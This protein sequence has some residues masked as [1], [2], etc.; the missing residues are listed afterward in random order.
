MASIPLYYLG[1]VPHVLNPISLE[2]E[3]FG[4]LWLE[5][6]NRFPI[7]VGYW[8]MKE[9][10]EI[11]QNAIQ[12]GFSKWTEVSEHYIVMNMYRSIR[13]KQQEQDWKQRTRLSIRMIFK[14]PWR[15]VP[16]GLYVIK[17]RETFPLHASAICKKKFFVWLEHAAVCETEQELQAFIRRVQKEHHAENIMKAGS[18][19]LK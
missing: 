10:S 11:T 14:T 6:N 12:S 16:A 17:S 19:S 18:P 7:I 2:Y 9:K 15:D 8:F 1:L 3:W 4:V 5:E 13:N